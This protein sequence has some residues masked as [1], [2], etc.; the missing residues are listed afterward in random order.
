MTQLSVADIAAI[1]MQDRDHVWH[2]LLQHRA[3][4]E[5]RDLLVIREANGT[6]LIDAEGN[7]YLDAYS[8]P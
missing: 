6:T 3:L 8:G 1:R 2:P 4:E 5:G 7:A